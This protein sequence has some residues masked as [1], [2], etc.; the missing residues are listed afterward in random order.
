MRRLEFKIKPDA[1]WGSLYVFRH[2]A[3]IHIVSANKNV[4]NA[5]IKV[6]INSDIKLD[7]YL[8]D[9]YTG[10]SEVVARTSLSR[11]DNDATARGGL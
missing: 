7:G 1:P 8:V 6:K 9:I 4:M 5:L 10:K 11:I 2:V 3:Q